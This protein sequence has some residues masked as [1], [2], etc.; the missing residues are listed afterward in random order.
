IDEAVYQFVIHT[1]NLSDPVSGLWYHGWTFNGR[2]NFAKAFWARGNA[3]ITF[4][5]PELFDLVPTL[6]EKDRRFMSNVLVSQ[7]RSL[8]A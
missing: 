4:A 5:I 7:V 3:W 1:R 8:K 2:H 6:A